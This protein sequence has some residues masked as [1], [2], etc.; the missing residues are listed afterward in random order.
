MVA[1]CDIIFDRFELNI[2]LDLYIINKIKYAYDMKSQ[3]TPYKEI[4]EKHDRVRMF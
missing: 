3:S 1:P 4:S 2:M